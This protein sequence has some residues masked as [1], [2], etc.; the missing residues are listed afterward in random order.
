MLGPPRGV[1]QRIAAPA[2]QAECRGFETRLPLHFPLVPGA[3][4][5]VFDERVLGGCGWGAAATLSHAMRGR[6]ASEIDRSSAAIQALDAG[7]RVNQRLA[8]GPDA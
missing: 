4:F 6:P 8:H 1:P 5:S 7:L 2:F 3:K